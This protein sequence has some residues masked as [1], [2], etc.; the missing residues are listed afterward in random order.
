MASTP[1]N[2]LD[3]SHAAA[4]VADLEDYNLRNWLDGALT[5]DNELAG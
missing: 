2:A 4:D 1:F 5:D 3:L